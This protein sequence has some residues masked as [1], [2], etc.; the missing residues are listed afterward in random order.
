MR[1]HL[2]STCQFQYLKS[3]FLSVGIL[4]I[5]KFF[6]NFNVNFHPFGRN[7]QEIGILG[8]QTKLVVDFNILSILTKSR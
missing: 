4:E 2:N 8:K 7:F 3:W 5:G 6:E 1:Y